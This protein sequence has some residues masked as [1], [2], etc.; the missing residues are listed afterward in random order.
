MSPEAAVRAYRPYI[1]AELA[2]GTPL[3]A[4]VRHMLGLFHG[5]PG[6]RA[7]RRILTVEGVKAGAGLE[8]V[9]QALEAVLGEAARRET[10]ALVRE[11]AC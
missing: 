8:V 9:D 5:R 4:I 2:R 7:W 11:A 10:A 3:Y 1:A 6:A